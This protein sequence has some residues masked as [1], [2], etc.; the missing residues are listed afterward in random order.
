MKINYEG[1][2]AHMREQMR[3]YIEKGRPIGSFLA[4]ILANDFVDAAGR[5]DDINQGRLFDYAKFLYNY[6]PT[7]CW[8]SRA[9]VNAWVAAQGGV[10]S[11]AHEAYL[12]ADDAARDTGPDGAEIPWLDTGFHKS[13]F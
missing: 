7:T 4:A 3:A 11:A 10:G 2:P 9:K 1:L 13:R 12:A 5:A 8:G 6:A